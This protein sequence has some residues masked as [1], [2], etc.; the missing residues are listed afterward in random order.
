MASSP[1]FRASSGLDGGRADE[2]EAVGD[3]GEGR[4]DDQRVHGIG[5]VPVGTLLEGQ[6]VAEEKGIKAPVLGT[7][8]DVDPVVQI[9]RGKGITLG[10]APAGF[11]AAEAKDDGIETHAPAVCHGVVPR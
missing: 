7:T 11:M 5:K 10:H 3:G 1:K 9:S 2:A 4:E 8:G 6:Y